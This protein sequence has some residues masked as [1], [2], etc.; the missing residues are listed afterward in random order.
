MACSSGYVPKRMSL[1][2][3]TQGFNGFTQRDNGG[4]SIFDFGQTKLSSTPCWKQKWL[5]HPKTLDC[6]SDHCLSVFSFSFGHCGVRP[7]LIYGYW[8]SIR[9]PLYLQM[10]YIYTC[11]KYFKKCITVLLTKSN[12]PIISS[13]KAVYKNNH[14]YIYVFKTYK[15]LKLGS[16][17]HGH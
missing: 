11:M 13:L 14:I 10:L 17:F 4:Y 12:R 9:R 2:E 15:T 7:S 8:L 5:C 3:Y 6:V 16:F 1:K